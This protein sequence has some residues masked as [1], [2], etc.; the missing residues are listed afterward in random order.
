MAELALYEFCSFYYRQ[1]NNAKSP[2]FINGITGINLLLILKLNFQ[3]NN[4][5]PSNIS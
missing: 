2:L 3:N 5:L 1:L 4:P